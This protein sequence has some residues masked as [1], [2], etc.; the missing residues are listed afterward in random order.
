M[1]ESDKMSRAKQYMTESHSL[2]HYFNTVTELSKDWEAH[3]GQRMLCR[4]LF[5]ENKKS[6]FVQ[7]GR[8]WG[9][10]EIILYFLWRYA[11]ERPGASCYYISPYQKQSKE[12]IWANKRVHNFGP[13]DWL[14]EGSIGINNTELRINFKNGSFIK[15]DGSDNYESYRGVEP[16]ILIMEEYKDHRPEFME[17]MRPNLAVY[18]APTIFIG[19][20]PEEDD[21]FFWIDADEHK[22]HKDKFFYQ[23]PTWENP[24][25]DREWLGQEKKRLYSRGEGDV[26]EREY[27]AA[28]V[29]G[30]AS[31]IFPM[32]NKDIVKP[33][34]DVMASIY[35]DRRK[36]D[37]FVWTDPAAAS[38]FGAIYIAIN[39]YTK[40]IYALDEI[41]EKKQE[42]LTV[43]RVGK[44]IVDMRNELFLDRDKKWRQGYDEAETWFANEMLDHFDE[45]FEPTQ[46][47]KSDKVTG[48]TLLKDVML[49][50]RLTISDRCKNLYW[51]LDHYRKDKNGKIPKENDHLIDCFRYVLDASFYTLV[52][53]TE[54]KREESENWRGSRISDDFPGFDEW[55]NKKDDWENFE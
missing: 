51:E 2:T 16:H 44:R 17:G 13:R 49:Q 18:N 8:K 47:M 9:K 38:C 3:P 1:S 15:C 11:Q 4:K 41:Y 12:I 48:L 19:T 29:K 31:K 23:A 14:H 24:H 21:H 10:T 55:G 46:K 25:I 30:G 7:C 45:Y 52:E 20:P 39:P 43:K 50:G 26:W 28:R 35:R 34:H 40:H 6:L 22:D 27:G 36:L 32:L 54:E 33:H 53:K 5:L 42:E 37:W